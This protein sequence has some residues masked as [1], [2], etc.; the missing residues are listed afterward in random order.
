[1]SH[2][3]K[4]PV[5]VLGCRSWG[6]LRFLKQQQGVR[7]SL[8]PHLLLQRTEVQVAMAMKQIV[9]AQNLISEHVAQRITCFTRRTLCAHN[10]RHWR[11][12]P[13]L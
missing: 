2:A 5:R 1:M 13:T 12:L 8:V 4:A 9:F 7:P 10:H 6:L 11:A 3:A